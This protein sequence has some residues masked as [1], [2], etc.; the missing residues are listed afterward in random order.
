MKCFGLDIGSS[1]I[2]GAVL[3]LERQEVGPAVREDFPAPLGGL[4][5]GYF[6]VDPDAVFRV[7]VSV[8]AKLFEAAP[9][10][11]ALYCSGQMGGL[12]LVDESGKPLTNYLSWRDQRTLGRA[13]DAESYLDT[14]RQLWGSEI[15]REL[16]NELAPGSA[17]SLL[18]WLA[19]NKLL[20]ARAMPS[21]IADYVLSRLCGVLPQMHETQAVGL[22]NLTTSDWH[23]DA[24]ARL[25]LESVCLPT[26]AN[27]NEPIGRFA[28]GGSSIACH[29]SFGDQQCA[30]C[31][32]DL[33]SDELSLNISTGSQV[34]CRTNCFEPGNYQTRKYF[35]GGFLNTITHLPAGRSLN[36]LLDLLTELARAEGISLRRVWPTIAQATQQIESVEQPSGL[37]VNLA[38]FAGPLGASGSIN[39]ITTEN[40]TVGKLFHAAFESM[41]DNYAIC[42][43]RLGQIERLNRVVLSGG[44]TQSFPVLRQLI[45]QR[46]HIPLRDSS[47]VEETLTG[48]LREATSQIAGR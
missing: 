35:D 47:L 48:L 24:L 20:P 7:T 38:F 10:G 8:L 3:D 32:A 15:I 37:T 27:P 19:R 26:I 14:I 17:M 21:T 1:T 2:K 18:Y 4:P 39:G 33:A 34:S 40:L 13:G 36:A 22:L 25:G 44:L 5:T 45:Q 9:D 41:A 42:A 12:I 6:E 31:G 16:G 46:L 29:A 43:A 23:R 11:V 30:L 28:A